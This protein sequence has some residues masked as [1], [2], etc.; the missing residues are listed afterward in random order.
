MTARKRIFIVA[1]EHSGDFLGAALMRSLRSELEHP[2]IYAGV[3]G[4]SME[5]E[6]LHSLFP[7]RDVAV[8]GLTAIISRLP[9]LIKRVFQT[10]NAAIKFAPDIVVVIDSPEFTHPI[11]RRIRRKLP[12]VPI[13][14]YVSPSVWAW[15][16][17]RAK[18]MKSYVDHILAL[19]PFEPEAH[20]R[21]CGPVCTYVGHPLVEKNDFIKQCSSKSLQT[22]LSIADEAVK[23]VVLPGSR[24]NEVKRLMA[25]FGEAIEML[26]QRHEKLEILIPVM[27]TVEALI[28]ELSSSWSVTPHLL[29]GESDKYAAFNLAN[30]AFAAS[31]T[32]TL[33]LG[34]TKVPMVVA[35]IMGK[36]EYSLRR[37]VRVQSIVLANLVLGENV[38]PEFLQENCTTDNLVAA[39]DELLHETPALSAQQQGLN[40]VE[41]KILLEGTTPSR[42][43][44]K[45]VVSYLKTTTSA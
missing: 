41:K 30:A 2:A 16:P 43:A 6:G 37:M 23:L 18:R 5:L 26:R 7:L 31:G 9:T 19:L 15:R 33:E 4:S 11:A 20:K 1:G 13:I 42:E 29:R 39:M 22:R 38:F 27:P 21:L 36:P 28:R 12:D 44:A 14:D 35:Y 45:V 8:M 24:P 3:G 25:P 40:L 32:V 10:V 34:L 17:W